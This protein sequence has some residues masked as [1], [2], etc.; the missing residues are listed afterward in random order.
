MNPS[1]SRTLNKNTVVFFENNDSFSW[2]II[3]ALPFP[4]SEIK[5]VPHD[6]KASLSESLAN[7][8]CVVIGPGPMDPIR[9]GLTELVHLCAKK[10]IPTLGICLGFQAIGMAF[11]SKLI[12]TTPVHG[13]RSWVNTFLPHVSFPNLPGQFEVMRYHSLSLNSIKSPRINI[14][15]TPDGI[16]MALEHETLPIA[17]FQFHPDSFATDRGEEMIHSFFKYAL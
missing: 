7:A 15:S 4:R 17:G 2:N 10:K 12:R 3:D 6:T 14:A 13:K 1:G 9:T 11:E 8:S 16:P 5:I